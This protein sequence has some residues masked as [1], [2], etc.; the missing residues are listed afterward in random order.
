VPAGSL[1]GRIITTAGSLSPDA[2][3]V[4]EA[5]EVLDR[6]STQDGPGAAVLIARG[7]KVI[8]RSARGRAEIELGVPLSPDNV[9][10]IGSVTKMFTA[11]MILKLA[12]AG[13]LSLDDP[14]A[15]YLPD[16]PNGAS[17]TIRQLLTHTAGISETAK[18]PQPGFSRR[19]IDTATQI[20]E[21]SKRP[22]DFTPGTRWSYSNAGFI[23][24]G[25]VIEKVTGEFWHTAIAKQILEPLGMK[26]TLYGTSAPLILG[27]ASGYTTDNPGHI[28][29]NASFI[30]ATIPAAAG[31]L[32]STVDDLRLWMRA[33]STGRVMSKEDFEQM[34]TPGPKL[35]GTRTTYGYGLGTF[36][37]HVRGNTMIGHTGQIPGFASIVGYLP[38]RDIT[39]IA[40]GNDD[41]FDAQTLGRRLAAVALGKTYPEVVPGKPTE[42]ELRSLTGTYVI[43][44]NTIETLS[45]RGDKLYAQRGSREAIPLQMTADKQLHFVPDE[46]S[47]F[48]P[49]RDAV[50]RIVGLDY[51]ENGDGP[52][53]RLPRN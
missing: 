13:K 29:E 5:Q 49:V 9:F 36:V 25:A 34:I 15:L 48:M 16:F 39:V 14:L 1:A 27:R 38:E 52:P 53:R 28:V 3:I 41:N 33:L 30:S 22:L 47:Y 31:A 2:T 43:D 24:L 46:L 19:D 21:I 32:V 51:F 11:A 4:Q 18:D 42:G 20:A 8:Y 40:L 10:R 50:G 12:E 35:P 7:D 37:F 6:V 23:L 17:I 45:V 26:H 44:E